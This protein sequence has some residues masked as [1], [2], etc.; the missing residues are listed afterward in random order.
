M[1]TAE[2]AACEGARA[3]Q[4]FWACRLGGGGP[5]GWSKDLDLCWDGAQGV[6]A[7]IESEEDLAPAYPRWQ[8]AGVQRAK[9]AAKFKCQLWADKAPRVTMDE[10]E[11]G[12]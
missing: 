6:V 3:G 11:K 4:G 10:S 1:S 2:P 7:E 8:H 9:A 5:G 12:A